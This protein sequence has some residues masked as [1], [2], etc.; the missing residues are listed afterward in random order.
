MDTTRYFSELYLI[1]V[2]LYICVVAYPYHIVSYS[3]C[4]IF[5]YLGHLSSSSHLSQTQSLLSKVQRVSL[6]FRVRR[7]KKREFF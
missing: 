5:L 4:R 1:Y 7:L 2:P 6:G 3:G